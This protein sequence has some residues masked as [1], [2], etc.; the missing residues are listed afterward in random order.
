[1]AVCGMKE[2]RKGGTGRAW[3]SLKQERGHGLGFPKLRV[4]RGFEGLDFNAVKDHQG[5]EGFQGFKGL[6]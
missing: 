1:M 5:F 2:K 3:Q 6:Y 4:F